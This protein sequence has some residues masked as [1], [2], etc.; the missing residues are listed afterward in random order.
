MRA[1]RPIA[2]LLCL[3]LLCPGAGAQAPVISTWTT[4][5]V[6]DGLLSRSVHCLYPTADGGLLVGT[7][8]GLNRW[9]GARW[10]Q[11]SA[12]N[13]LAEGH[14]SAAAELQGAV[15]AGSW[16]GGLSVL[17]ASGW[18]TYRAASSPLPSDWIADL[19]VEDG[20]LWIATYGGG[21][22]ALTGDTWRVYR[23]N[24]DAADGLPSDWLTRVLPDGAGGIWVGSESAGLAHL[25]SDGGWERAA[26]PAAAQ[27][28]VTA[29][30]WR[31]ADAADAGRR[32]LWVGTPD[33]VLR[34]AQA[35]GGAWSPLPE[36]PAL[37]GL[38]VT[39]LAG[40]DDGRM[41]VGTKTGLMHWGPG[42][43]ALS[44]VRQGLPH[45]RVSALAV[46]AAGRA[47]VGT[48]TAGLAAAGPLP[49]PEVERLPVVL[50]HGW[51]SAESDLL[52]DSEFWHLAGWLREDG[53]RCY[54]ATGVSP[55]NTLYQ[56]ARAIS[57]TIARAR[58]E[59]DAERVILIG[60]SMGGLNARAYL[61]STLYRGDVARLFTLGSPHQ[62][63]DLWR[64]LLLWEHLA[65]SD[66]PSTLELL[67]EHMAF[68]NASH[69]QPAGVPYVL[70]AG[71]AGAPRDDSEEPLPT[72]FGELTPGDGL[73]STWS[74][75]G[76]DALAAERRV[77]RDLHAWAEQTLLLDLPSLLLPRG[78]Y[79]AHIR[80][81]LFGVADA[82]GAGTLLAPS[83]NSGP[84]DV[85]GSALRTGTLQPGQSVTLTPLPVD[86][87][88][89]MRVYLRWRGP[90]PDI[91]LRDPAGVVHGASRTGGASG[92]EGGVEYIEL[93]FAEFAGFAVDAA[94]TGAW[95]VTLSAPA[96]NKA[97]SE[98]AVYAEWPDAQVRLTGTSES[99]WAAPGATVTITASVQGPAEVLTN[100]VSGDVYAPSG[101]TQA[102]TFER[103][104][105]SGDATQFVARYTP[106]EAGYHFALL[107]ALGTRAGRAWERGAHVCVTVRGEGAR[108]VALEEPERAAGTGSDLTAAVELDVAAPGE[109]LLTLSLAEEGQNE[110]LCV[111]HPL[112]LAAGSQRVEVPLTGLALRSGAWYRLQ[113]AKLMDITGAGILVDATDADAGWRYRHG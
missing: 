69:A 39:A 108:I 46:D 113:Q 40:A 95:T 4:Y 20:T 29:L 35:A 89:R 82:P 72:L 106:Q 71:D 66:E 64:T 18:R 25:R 37:A 27:G 91:S 61:E 99:V 38:A 14:I 30:A 59:T 33:G 98:Y 48:L 67:P 45:N 75:L 70:I 112:R 90:A 60:F 13:G 32:E 16:G 105:T 6:R 109:Y 2:A 97:A 81:Y 92:T 3:A 96:A 36:D 77:S 104:S 107:T 84:A 31:A 87:R 52:E 49:R 80:P 51:R 57:D 103:V 63:E 100:A 78:T 85:P 102:L 62:G 79:D 42:E 55:V 76:P 1:R 68:Y 73:V 5:G 10:L 111:A 7:S 94:Q 53:F 110:R 11:Y 19:A 41:W 54:Y 65:W 44:T 21:L 26:L 9:D 8:G 101:A 43:A 86:V 28:E 34:L 15:W 47:W 24:A 23:R 74:A 12:G 93:G 22:A 17:Q 56:N 58:R 50:V 88:G 83:G